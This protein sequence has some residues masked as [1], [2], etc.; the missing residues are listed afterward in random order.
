LNHVVAASSKSVAKRPL[1]SA[2]ANQPPRPNH[3]ER[4]LPKAAHLQTAASAPVPSPQVLPER[5]RSGGVIRQSVVAA[6]AADRS[7]PKSQAANTADTAAHH[8]YRAAA[9]NSKNS[10]GFSSHG[11][12]A[13]P[14]AGKSAK[15]S[16]SNRQAVD[17]FPQLFGS[18]LAKII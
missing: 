15:P 13:K 16:A 2:S 12:P 17:N 14:L 5:T 3:N 7:D 10:S 1:S 6:A 4:S 9:D 18:W 11:V 8:R